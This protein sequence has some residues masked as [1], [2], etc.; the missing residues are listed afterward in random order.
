[1]AGC[2][3]QRFEGISVGVFGCLQAKGTAAGVPIAGEQGQATAHGVTLRWNFDAA[4]EVLVIE[5]LDR[6]VFVSCS[7]ITSTVTELI[8]TCKPRAV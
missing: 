4:L 3:A 7:R 8:E 5:C 2:E 1:M 6:P